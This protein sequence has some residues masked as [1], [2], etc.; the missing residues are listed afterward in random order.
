MFT[1]PLSPFLCVHDHLC[2]SVCTHMCTLHICVVS[3]LVQVLYS[4]AISSAPG[5]VTSFH[6][7]AITFL[8]VIIPSWVSWSVMTSNISCPSPSVMLYSI[9][10][11]SPTSASLALI[12][13]IGVPG[14]EDSGVLNWYVPI[15]HQTDK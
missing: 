10:A 1:S 3:G 6:N 14:G 2:V 4:A 8:T 7:N 12:L 11:F 9:S 13:P 15:K 5:V